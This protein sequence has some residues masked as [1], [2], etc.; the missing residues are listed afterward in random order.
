MA[1]V[2]AGFSWQIHAAALRTVQAFIEKLQAASSASLPQNQVVHLT[3]L[4]PGGH[5]QP[6]A[7]QCL[8]SASCTRN[9]VSCL[10][11][12]RVRCALIHTSGGSKIISNRGFALLQA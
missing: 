2:A 5:E 8:S 6:F 7:L 1:C 12:P 9:L 3:H 4:V 11:Q 10:C